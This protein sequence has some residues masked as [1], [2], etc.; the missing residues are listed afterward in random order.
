MRKRL[1]VGGRAILRT[2]GQE[3]EIQKGRDGG[4]FDWNI[5]TDGSLTA[6][7]ARSLIQF[8]QAML[9]MISTHWSGT[10]DINLSERARA[11]LPHS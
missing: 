2:N 1:C 4:R 3:R 11:V 7:P 10:A 5:D 9:N 6:G 8:I